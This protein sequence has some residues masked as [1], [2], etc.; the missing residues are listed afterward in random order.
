[1]TALEIVALY[2][3]AWQNKHGDFSDVPLADDFAFTG[4]V[5][6]FDT[7]DG[8][9]AMA[10]EAGAA[11]FSRRWRSEPEPSGPD[12]QPI[13]AQQSPGRRRRRCARDPAP[14]ARRNDGSLRHHRRDERARK[15][16]R[17]G[18]GSFT[19]RMRQIL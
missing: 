17:P 11:V 12:E 8:Y 6:S 18:C 5:A 19:R 7:A 10:A 1:M 15:H 9:R 3:D 16:R 14:R 4:P 13:G 2:Y